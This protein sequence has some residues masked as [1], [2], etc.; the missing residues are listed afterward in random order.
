VKKNHFNFNAVDYSE[1]LSF[2]KFV[3]YVKGLNL[4]ECERHLRLQS[5]LIDLNHV[6]FIG[7]LE[8]I[9]AD[10]VSLC[11]KLNLTAEKLETRNISPNRENYRNYYSDRLIEEVFELYEKDIRLFNYTY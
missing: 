5:S 9:E 4:T 3:S 6:D 11:S 2:P 8:N 10:H 7:R 1:M